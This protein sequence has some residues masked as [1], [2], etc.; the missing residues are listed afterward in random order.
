MA[1]VATYMKFMGRNAR[2]FGLV[3]APLVMG[4]SLCIFEPAAAA[5]S[6]ATSALPW[7]HSVA[8]GRRKKSKARASDK[9]KAAKRHRRK[10]APSGPVVAALSN[11][12]T[13]RMVASPGPLHTPEALRSMERV[14]RG[15]IERAES[16]ARRDELS[17]RWETVLFLLSGVEN[18][19]Y[20]E[21]AFWKALASYRRGD[22]EG[23]DATRRNCRLPPADARA[24]DEERSVASLLATRDGGPSA[25]MQP[26]AFTA[27]RSSQAIEGVH[28]NAAYTGPAPTPQTAGPH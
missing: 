18:D 2:W 6:A 16:A 21:A 8:Q 15:Q 9:R 13:P 25:G 26:A 17:N 3:L 14:R 1:R 10:H 23:G 19:A 4:A 27:T 24:L 5:G 28:N 11:P 7:A 12:V 20:P 22:F